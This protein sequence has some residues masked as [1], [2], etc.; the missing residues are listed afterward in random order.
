MIV[1]TNVLEREESLASQSDPG[2]LA[3]PVRAE[4]V[5]P[6]RVFV[7]DLLPTVPYYTGYLCAAMQ[8][9]PNVDLSVGATIYS[10]DPAFFARMGVPRKRGLIDFAGRLPNSVKILRRAL[11]FGEYLL[12]LAILTLRFASSRP[13]IVHVQFTPLIDRHLPYEIW[14]LKYVRRLGCKIVYTVHNV[15][16]HEN[17]ERYRARYAK[18]YRLVDHFICHDPHAQAALAA[19]FQVPP[20]TVSI[21]PHGP[22]FSPAHDC[23][24]RQARAKTGLSPDACIVLWQGI[25]RPYKGISFLLKAW[26]AACQAGLQ[27]TLVIVGTGEKDVVEAVAQEV[28]ALDIASSVRLDFRFV[29]VEMLE[30]Y[31]LAADILVYPYTAITT[32][33]ALMTG[34]GYGKAMIAS[35]LPAFEEML[36]N[37]KNALLVPYGDV[38][39]WAGALARLASDADLRAR[40]GG[41][42]QASCAGTPRW[43]DIACETLRVY[44]QVLTS[45]STSR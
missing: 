25:I 1:R 7:M 21:V 18:V 32:S 37:D 42:L 26:K 10:H 33:G 3:Y 23:T 15:L 9:Q 38:D 4:T 30:A 34:M 22:L 29:S 12:N 20:D 41:R 36:Q 14:F 27:A 16:P 35:A 43:T 31:H 8:N 17:G 11:K 6:V 13:D 45:S 39:G 5:R 2:R 40:L 19:E 28:Q 44:E 24:P